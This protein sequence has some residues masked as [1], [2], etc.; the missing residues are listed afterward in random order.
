MAKST[1]VFK[2]KDP[3]AVVEIKRQGRWWLLFYVYDGERRD[4]RTLLAPELGVVTGI[5]LRYF[6]VNRH[7]G[8]K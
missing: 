8:L 5:Q 1:K 6:P 2:M 7:K 4:M 3:V